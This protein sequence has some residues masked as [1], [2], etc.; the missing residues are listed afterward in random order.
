MSQGLRGYRKELTQR[1]ASLLQ[2]SV[3]AQA[4]K[5]QEALLAEI[6]EEMAH[7]TQV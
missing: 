7:W 3:E 6:V 2:D 5:G 4:L 1:R